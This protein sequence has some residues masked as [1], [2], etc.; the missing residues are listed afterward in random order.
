MSPLDS[1]RKSS[2]GSEWEKYGM[3]SPELRAEEIISGLSPTESAFGS[4]FGSVFGSP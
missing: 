4:P 3:P 1:P 2:S